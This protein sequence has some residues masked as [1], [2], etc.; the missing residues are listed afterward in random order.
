M[1]EPLH[2]LTSLG[3]SGVDCAEAGVDCAEAGAPAQQRP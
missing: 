1:K 2:D 3:S